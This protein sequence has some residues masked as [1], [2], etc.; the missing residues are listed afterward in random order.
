MMSRRIAAIMIVVNAVLLATFLL[1]LI[2]ATII[3]FVSQF[4]PH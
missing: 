3:A 4:I 2:T 1:A